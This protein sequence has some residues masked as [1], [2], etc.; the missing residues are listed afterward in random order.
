MEREDQERVKAAVQV[1]LAKADMDKISERQVRKLASQI[2]GLD[3]S[4]P[5]GKKLVLS[6][7]KVFLD[8]CVEEQKVEAEVSGEND[9]HVEEDQIEERTTIAKRVRASVM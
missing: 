7:I 3:L 9:S 1:I 4:L 8:S 5:A 2:T 6:L